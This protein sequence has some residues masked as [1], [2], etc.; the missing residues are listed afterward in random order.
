LDASSVCGVQ[1]LSTVSIRRP[2][3][4]GIVIIAGAESGGRIPDVEPYN[5]SIHKTVTGKAT[6][7][8]SWQFKVL[9]FGRWFGVGFCGF[10]IVL[11]I[12]YWT[13]ILS[14][15]AD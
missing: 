2:F 6:K 3:H 15:P 1:P 4:W 12:C 13:G 11:T 10:I 5:E 7:P 9:Q 14:P 8:G